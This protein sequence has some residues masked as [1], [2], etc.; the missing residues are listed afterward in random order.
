MNIVILLCI[1]TAAAYEKTPCKGTSKTGTT[2]KSPFVNKESGY[3]TI[4]NPNRTKCTGKT[5][6]GAPCGMMVMKGAT[7]CRLHITV[8]K[9]N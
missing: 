9:K 4:H 8:T 7:N 5:T 1:T 3:C 6:K 2:C